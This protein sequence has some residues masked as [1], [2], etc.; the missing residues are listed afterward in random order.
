MAALNTGEWPFEA[1]AMEVVGDIEALGIAERAREE[2]DETWVPITAALV[3]DLYGEGEVA[4]T[5]LGVAVIPTRKKWDEHTLC[6]CV[7]RA[8]KDRWRSH[9][10]LRMMTVME[11]AE[12]YDTQCAGGEE[13]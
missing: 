12:W 1:M 3:E 5:E 8:D 4:R 9:G 11:Y 13:R 7:V 2:G 6:Y 10:L